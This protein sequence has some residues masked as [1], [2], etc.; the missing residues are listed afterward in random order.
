MDKI[1]VVEVCPNCGSE[2][3]MQW[4]FERYGLNAFCPVCGSHMMLCDECMNRED[5]VSNCGGQ[6]HGENCKYFKKI[7]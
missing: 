2:N 1:E 3:I 6:I 5:Y 4:D 7:N